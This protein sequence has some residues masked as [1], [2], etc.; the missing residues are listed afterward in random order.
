MFEYMQKRL[1]VPCSLRFGDPLI[2]KK[3]VVESKLYS[4]FVKGI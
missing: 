2:P 4:L 3:K 1:N